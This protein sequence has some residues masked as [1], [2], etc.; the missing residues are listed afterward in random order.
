M[1]LNNPYQKY[2]SE[3]ECIVEKVING[4]PESSD[5]DRLVY[6][7]KIGGLSDRTVN[8]LYKNCKI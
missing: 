4:R 3:L 1:S 5:F 2:F 8:S 6:L 7:L